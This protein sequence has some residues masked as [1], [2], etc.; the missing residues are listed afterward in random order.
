MAKKD[1]IISVRIDPEI[2]EKAEAILS[3]RGLSHSFVLHML[4]DQIILTNAIPFRMSLPKESS[5]KA[6][7]K[8]D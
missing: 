5:K 3:K 4:Y 7:T 1:S 2:K 8:Q 6:K